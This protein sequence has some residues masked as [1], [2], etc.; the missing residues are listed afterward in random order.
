M[1]Q[2][3][4]GILYFC[5]MKK[6]ASWCLRKIFYAYGFRALELAENLTLK[7]HAY[8]SQKHAYVEDFIL[9]LNNNLITTQAIMA[10][11]WS[12]T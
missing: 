6:D 3:E 9:F 5:L 2:K 7:M 8:G 11:K 1:N 4:N 10:P 12:I